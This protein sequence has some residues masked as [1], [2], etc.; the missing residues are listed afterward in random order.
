MI[1]S[2]LREKYPELIEV[3][4]KYDCDFEQGIKI[5]EAA[6][7]QGSLERWVK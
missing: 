1:S 5:I 4:R 6:K 7:K 3:C 2:D